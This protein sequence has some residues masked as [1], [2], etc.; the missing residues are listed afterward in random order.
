[1]KPAASAID[2]DR[3]PV[4]QRTTCRERDHPG[5]GRRIRGLVARAGLSPETDALFTITPPPA[6]SITGTAAAIAVG[7]CR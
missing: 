2:A 4:L 1:M 7:K 6:S 5:L 3:R